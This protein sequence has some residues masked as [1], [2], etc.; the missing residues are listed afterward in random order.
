MNRFHSP[1]NV[2]ACDFV[3][4]KRAHFDLT[5]CMWK[6]V[7]WST[8]Q[9]NCGKL[10]CVFLLLWTSC[11]TMWPLIWSA[12]FV[13]WNRFA[14]VILTYSTTWPGRSVCGWVCTKEQCN[15][16]PLR[17]RHS[18]TSWYSSEE[19]SGD[20]STMRHKATLVKWFEV[21]RSSRR[22]VVAT[23]TVKRPVTASEFGL[24]V[25]RVSC[26]GWDEMW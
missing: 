1:K 26:L 24:S 3:K 14:G 2:N 23:R 15:S 25:N 12:G 21:S 9:I 16:E 19:A 4:N 6:Y 8:S 18:S 5:S 17:S 11:M 10:T 20:S 13:I 7:S 22:R